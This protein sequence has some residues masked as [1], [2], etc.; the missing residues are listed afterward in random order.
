MESPS[1]PTPNPQSGEKAE[2]P[3]KRERIREAILPSG[4]KSV[5]E[6]EKEL[7]FTRAH[8]GTQFLVVTAISIGAGVTFIATA[9]AP[10][11][12][13]YIWVWSIPFFI[14]AFFFF[15]LALR[16]TRHAYILLTPL[17]IEIFPFFK[18]R[19]NLQVVYWS[20]IKG[21]DIDE[22]TLTLHFNEE[23]TAGIKASLKPISKERRT[24]LKQAIDGTV[25][26]I[27]A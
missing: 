1:V 24:L 5:A 14:A 20:Q 16:C 3:N 12:P 4:P 23:Q 7:R 21:V 13:E 19:E 2:I 8:Q 18:P 15:R 25:N 22:G 6:P 9:F 10:E 27:G 26:R 17:G 11:S